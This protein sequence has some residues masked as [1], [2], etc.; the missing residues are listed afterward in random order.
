M[1]VASSRISLRPL[2]PVLGKLAELS[3][4]DPFRVAYLYGF[5]AFGS[6]CAMAWAEGRLLR[7]DVLE[8]QGKSTLVYPL[9][10]NLSTLLDFLVLNPLA[11]FL[12]LDVCRSVKAL[13]ES[14]GAPAF[15][16]SRAYQIIGAVAWF[17]GAVIS[18]AIYLHYFFDGDYLDAIVA[19]DASGN[20]VLTATGWVT[21][22]WTVLF[23]YGLGHA[24]FAQVIYL[25][26]IS[27]LTP[28]SID[29][30]P[31]ALDDSGGL[32]R[33]AE[34]TAKFLRINFVLLITF[35]LF[36]V[37]DR[38]LFEVDESV[39]GIGA[40]IYLG[41]SVPLF[42]VPLFRLRSIMKERRAMIAESIFR[43]LDHSG[44]TR[45][46]KLGRSEAEVA[47]SLKAFSDIRACLKQLPTWPLPVR[48]SYESLTMLTGPALSL[49]PKL[50]SAIGI[51]T[52]SLGHWLERLGLPHG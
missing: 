43:M 39:R 31:F 19:P 6:T 46:D 21:S 35:S 34:P 16:F 15:R 22:F 3:P 32:W 37:Q 12:V 1:S 42:L 45:A 17:G 8:I 14:Y 4:L 44:L 49:I 24:I 11:L 51:L 41:V 10:L 20:C 2:D 13:E 25:R 7:F 28:D 18:M 40:L 38:I 50:T 9:V 26:L 47:E 33:T 27:R 52:V 30:K 5:L 23:M 36:A 29:Y 48:Q